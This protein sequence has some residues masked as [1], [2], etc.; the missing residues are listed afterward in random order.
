MVW[1]CKFYEKGD[2]DMN[3]PVCV[4]LCATARATLVYFLSVPPF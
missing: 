4:L 3:G 1:R 2:V